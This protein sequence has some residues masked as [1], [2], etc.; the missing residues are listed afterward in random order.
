[1]VL[2]YMLLLVIAG[3]VCCSEGF[4]QR[5]WK[6]WAIQGCILG[7]YIVGGYS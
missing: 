5:S 1:M 6:Y 4:D 2:I 3:L 7:A